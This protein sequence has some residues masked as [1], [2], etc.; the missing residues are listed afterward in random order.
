ME[1]RK[2]KARTERNGKEPSV[3]G[4]V[5]KPNRKKKRNKCQLKQTQKANEMKKSAAL[6]E[7]S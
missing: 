5:K 4:S 2:R 6:Q 3:E 7:Q 1:E